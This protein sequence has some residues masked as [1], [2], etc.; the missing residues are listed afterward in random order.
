M[1]LTFLLVSIGVWLV[2]LSAAAENSAARV[3]DLERSNER[4]F[5]MIREG[6]LGKE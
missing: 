2:A 1:A 3:E 6:R 4:I 5:K